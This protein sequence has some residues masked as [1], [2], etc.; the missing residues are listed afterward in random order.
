[1]V[2]D[3]GVAMLLRYTKKLVEIDCTLLLKFAEQEKLM[4]FFTKRQGIEQMAMRLLSI[5]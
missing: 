4:L 2:A 5:F 1:M 3:N